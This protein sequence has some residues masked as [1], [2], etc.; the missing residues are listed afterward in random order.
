MKILYDHQ[1]FTLQKYGGISRYFYELLREFSLMDDINTD[2][3]LL[4]SNNK[5]I[6]N[7]K[8]VNHRNFFINKDFRGK[9]RLMNLFNKLNSIFYLNKQSFN[10]FHPT[11]YHPYFLRYLH[12]KP[13]VITVYDMIHEKFKYMFSINDKTTQYKKMLVDKANRIIAI[14]QSTKNDLIDI[15]NIKSEKI[16]VVYLGNSLIYRDVK[17]N[18]NLPQKYILF[19]GSRSIYKNFDFFLESISDIL[20][21]NRELYLVCAGGDNFKDMEVLKLKKLGVQNQVLQFNFDDDTL[22]YVYKNAIL[23][24]FPSLYEGFGIPILEAFSCGCPVVCSNTS[25]L[26][27]V[28]GD[29]VEYFDPYDK[30]SIK[31]AVERV[32]LDEELRKKMIER[33]KKR[34]EK[35]S[36]ENTAIKTKEIYK[37][38]LS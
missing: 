4:F 28:G 7:K 9:V 35:F 18:F 22:A 37:G 32:L 17:I 27:E 12:K 31:S 6:Y 10:I 11:Y 13:F 3:A 33:G 23:F 29:A 25:S 34:L 8:I 15:F 21:N 36:W 19:V 2:V 14:S 38:I 20:K 16:E 30:D 26:P 24:V 1:I 5:Y